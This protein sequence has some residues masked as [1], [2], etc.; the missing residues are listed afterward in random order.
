M[1]HISDGT[2]HL[3]FL[4]VLIL[5]APLICINKRWKSNPDMKQSFFKILKITIAF[6]IG[7]SLTLVLATLGIITFPRKPV[8]IVIAFSILIT[9]FHA[10]KPLFPNRENIVAGIFGLIHG[11]AFSSVLSELNLTKERLVLSLLGFNI[12][13]ELM[14]LIVIFL[15][16]PWLLMISRYKIYNYYKNFL[17]VLAIVASVSWIVERTSGQANIISKYLEIFTQNSILF[18]VF[19]FVSFLLF[20]IFKFKKINSDR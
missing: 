13:I 20:Y 5:T 10:L 9:A 15:V 1:K 4:L 12:G 7:H 14:Q 8:E 18:V 16:I 19:L 17:A 3:M 2:D 6:T 11:L